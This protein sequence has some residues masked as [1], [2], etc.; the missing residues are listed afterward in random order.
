[1]HAEGRGDPLRSTGETL[2]VVTSYVDL[3]DPKL[4]GTTAFCVRDGLLV[5]LRP[6]GWQAP[7]ETKESG[8]VYCREAR[9]SDPM[10]MPTRSG[11]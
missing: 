2:E 6:V 9:G 7:V 4:T 11:F 8:E 5:P 10:P 1:M 3:I